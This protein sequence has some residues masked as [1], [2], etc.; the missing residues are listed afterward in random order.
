MKAGIRT[1]RAELAAR[2]AAVEATLAEA[3]RS[4]ARTL[5]EWLV[6]AAA[7]LGRLEVWIRSERVLDAAASARLDGWV[8]R[9]A[10]GEPL[11]YVLGTAPFMGRDFACDARA[12]IPRPET[13]E[14]CARVL[15]DAK[16][17]AHPAPA[18][19][20][21][22]TGTG[23][24]AVTLAL[25]CPA[26][27]VT[28]IDLSPDALAL[29]R[30]NARRFGVEDRIVW[31]QDDL[32]TGVRAGSLQAVVSNPPYIAE[33]EWAHL[34]PEVRDHEPRLALVGGADGLA[35]IRRLIEQAGHALAPGGR[36]WME[37][38]H[39]QGP[40]VRECLA[41][42]GFRAVV[43]HRDCAGHERLVEARRA[44]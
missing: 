20:D 30:T 38:G 37:I 16:G 34:D 7:G 39:T 22:G 33:A 36:F 13:E 17:W 24:L 21:V 2:L 3:G 8:R 5:A 31:R 40:A 29:A 6:A 10:R 43:T 35:V 44:E 15:A 19:A 23:C 9:V 32:L 26:A 25:E 12:L 14:L 27:A 4:E 11:Q 41:Q 1:P 42:H 18:I 28:A